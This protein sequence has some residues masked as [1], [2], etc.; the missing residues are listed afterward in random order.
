MDN[1]DKIKSELEQHYGSQT[2]YKGFVSKS[3]YTDGIKDLLEKA[4]C[5]WLYDIIQTEIFALLKNKNPDIYYFKITS[6]SSEAKL[7]LKDYKSDVIYE[8]EI[9]FTDFPEGSLD[10]VIGFDGQYLTTCLPSE[11]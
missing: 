9:P 5:Y 4:Q 7:I 2:Y 8:R 6:K 10:L 3:I 1:I 11:N